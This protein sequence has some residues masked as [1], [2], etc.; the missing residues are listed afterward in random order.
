MSAVFR[1]IER[2][3]VTPGTQVVVG[4][5]TE[6]F[7]VS[8]VRGQRSETETNAGNIYF[9]PNDTGGMFV[10]GPGQVRI[11]RAPLNS[12]FRASQFSIDGQFA[13]DG[14]Q[15]GYSFASWKTWNAVE[16]K[17]EEAIT[18]LIQ[19]ISTTLDDVSLTSGIS[20]EQMERNSI[21]C[22]VPSAAEFNRG[23]GIWRCNVDVMVTSSVDDENARQKHFLRTS[24]VRDTLMDTTLAANLTALGENMT[25]IPKSV[26]E[27]SVSSEVIPDT[28]RW[29][30]KISFE[31]FFCG[32][33]IAEDP[34]ESGYIAAFGGG[35]VGDVDGEQIG[36]F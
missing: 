30:S 35:W 20:D 9:Q 31:V 26:G 6:K 8:F 2:H 27:F 15:M 12:F 7:N 32:S 11:V 18:R 19:T 17:L 1:I 4:F 25:I 13:G 22:S 36:T 3:L 5:D 24:Y 33:E 29:M 21:V 14:I 34:E 10:I 16:L 23:T 28:R